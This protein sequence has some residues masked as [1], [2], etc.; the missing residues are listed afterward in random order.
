MRVYTV[1]LRRHGLM[2]DDDL[3]LVREGF[4][5]P[6]FLFTFVWALWH[7]MWRATLWLF[8]A[9]A[10]VSL[11]AE[12]ALGQGAAAVALS[13]ALSFAIG[14]IADDLRRNHLQDQGFAVAGLVA[15]ADEDQALHRYLEAE[16]Y[17]AADIASALPQGV[18]S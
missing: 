1:H 18:P 5:W 13:L 4:S 9:V 8:I 17:V 11:T 2:P 15:A 14:F 16:P 7:R 6:A 3:V 10:A 12:A